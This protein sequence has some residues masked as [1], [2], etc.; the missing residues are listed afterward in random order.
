MYILTAP[1]HTNPYQSTPSMSCFS[2]RYTEISACSNVFVCFSD[3]LRITC[4]SPADHLRITC[5]SPG[6]RGHE[7]PQGNPGRQD[8]GRQ[9][10]TQASRGGGEGFEAAESHLEGVKG[11]TSGGS[12]QG[13]D[14]RRFITHTHM[15]IYIYIHLYIYIYLYIYIPI[16]IYAYNMCTYSVRIYI[17]I[18]M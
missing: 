18:Y 6:T 7:G 10:L 3:H 5:G 1:I 8:V 9:H 11:R 17:Y 2:Q 13:L 16:Y 12:N 15:Y 4:G 14:W